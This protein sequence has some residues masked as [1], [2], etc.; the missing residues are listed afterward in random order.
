MLVQNLLN[1]TIWMNF[2]Q[3]SVE[4][5]IPFFVASLIHQWNDKNAGTFDVVLLNLDTGR[6]THFLELLE[7]ELLAE[8]SKTNVVTIPDPTIKCSNPNLHKPEFFIILSDNYDHVSR[9]SV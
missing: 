1:F 5:H 9:F 3:K 2:Q 7:N 8:I 6:K 4:N